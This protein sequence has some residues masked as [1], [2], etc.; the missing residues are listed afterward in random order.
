MST[1]WSTRTAEISPYTP[2]EQP[3]D[4]KYI[5]LNTNENPYPPSPRVIQAIQANTNETL[6]LYP[7]PNSRKFREKIADYYRV[8]VDQV[9][10]GNGS[11]EILAFAYSAFFNPGDPIAYPDITYSFYPVYAQ[12]FDLH[13]RLV[14]L[15][16]DFSIPLEKF[17]DPDVG[18]IFPNPNAP[19]G[20]LLPLNA[21]VSLLDRCNR[22]IVIVDEAYIDFGGESATELIARYP[23][24]LVIFTL[25][26]SRAL[27]G[28]RL[29]YAIGHVDLIEGLN[30][31]KNSF[32][33]YTLDRLA[34]AGGVAAFEDEAWFLESRQKIMTTRQRITNNLRQIGFDVVESAANFIFIHHPAVEA[35]HIFTELK[36]RGI[37]V[38]Y[39]NLPRINNHLRVSIGTDSDMDIFFSNIRDIVNKSL[40]ENP[41]D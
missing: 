38:R 25:S 24:L 11:D 19:T 15:T 8:A 16:D 9:F 14:P 23:N 34:I 36:K 10:A 41:H 3:Q 6:R 29:G 17:N 18:I 26:K 40:S 20:K 22:K 39:F 1:F 21:I 5:K 31:I 35:Q 27:A 32:N 37:L 28:L 2:G 13:P 4:Q 30:R 12:L 7:D 33:S